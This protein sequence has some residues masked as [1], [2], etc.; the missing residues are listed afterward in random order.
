MIIRKKQIKENFFYYLIVCSL[1][2][3]TDTLWIRYS[4]IN[5]FYLI[6]LMGA[7]ILFIGLNHC[8]KRRVWDLSLFALP[9]IVTMIV[10]IDFNTLILYKLALIGICWA[11]VC[12]VQMEKLINYYIN[13]M[14]FISIFSFNYNVI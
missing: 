7:I 4:S 12:K 1:V 5:R 13:F 3:L 6:I 8:P 10:N 9:V 14:L 2:M 11:I